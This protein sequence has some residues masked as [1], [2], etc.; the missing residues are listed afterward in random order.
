MLAGTMLIPVK[1]QSYDSAVA[2]TIIKKMPIVT[3]AS[4]LSGEKRVYAY[5][6]S[7]LK[8][9]QKGYYIDS[10]KDEIVITNISKDG[11]AVYVKYP[12]SSS[13]TGYRSKWFRAVDILGLNN[14]YGAFSAGFHTGYCY[15]YTATSNLAVY[16]MSSAS[17]LKSYGSIAKGDYCY[18]L[19]AHNISGK[20]Y[21]LTVYPISAKKVNG[22]TVKSKAALAT[23]YGV[24]KYTL[25]VY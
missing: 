21:F 9:V 14:V 20:N 3:Y 6:D 17:T 23:K 4:P 15:S 24:S 7:S 5:S 16:R 2:N 12:S 22:V 10:F 18:T 1:A 13:S 8:N 11:K 19:G 25:K